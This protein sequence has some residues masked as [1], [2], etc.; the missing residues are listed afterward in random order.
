[1][2]MQELAG[3]VDVD[4]TERGELTDAE[5]AG[6]G[7]GDHDAVASVGDPGEEGADLVLREDG[8]EL[9]LVPGE[10]HEGGEV[11]AA[12]VDVAEEEP[13]GAGVCV[14]G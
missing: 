7:D 6:I 13:Q 5:A 14:V 2:D 11:G 12:R 10:G 9:A 1:M 4:D 3:A 8:G